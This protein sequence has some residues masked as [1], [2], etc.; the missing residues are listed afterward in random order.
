MGTQYHAGHICAMH[1]PITGM[2][3][4]LPSVHLHFMKWIPG[5]LFVLFVRSA[6]DGPMPPMDV[7]CGTRTICDLKQVLHTPGRKHAAMA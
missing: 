3:A 1:L 6:N 7:L 5:R 2:F 4:I